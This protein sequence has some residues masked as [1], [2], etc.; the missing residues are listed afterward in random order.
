MEWI[1]LVFKRKKMAAVYLMDPAVISSYNRISHD[2][3][4]LS[5]EEKHDMAYMQI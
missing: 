5:R 3:V 4:A 1:W 2:N